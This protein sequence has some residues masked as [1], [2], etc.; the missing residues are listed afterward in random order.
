MGR[1]SPWE[2]MVAHRRSTAWASV[3]ALAAVV[4]ACSSCSTAAS[5]ATTNG[6]GIGAHRFGHRAARLPPCRPARWRRRRGGHRA[7]RH[8][9][10]LPGRSA[11]PPGPAPRGGRGRHPGQLLRRRRR[12]ARPL[13]RRCGRLRRPVPV[14]LLTRGRVPGLRGG[15]LPRA[16]G[17]HRCGERQRPGPDP[18]TGIQRDSSGGELVAA[19]AHPGAVQHHLPRP[20]RPVRVVGPPAGDLRHPRHAPGPVLALRAPGQGPGP[21]GRVHPQ[22][23]QRRRTGLGRLHR[24]QARLRTARRVSTQSGLGRRHPGLLPEPDRPRPSG[25]VAGPRP[26]GPLHRRAGLAGHTVQQR[27]HR[28]GLRDHERAAG[29]QRGG[30]APGRSLHRVLGP[31]L[32]LL[33][34]GDRGADRCPRRPTHLSGRSA[35]QPVG[36]LRLPGPGP[37]RPPVD[38]L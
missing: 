26:P 32:P 38:V 17:V 29:R 30:A 14:G 7:G 2:R 22:H 31:A 23:R 24:R 21:P 6:S 15:C 10:R 35:H 25:A 34:P 27:S 12:E 11:G 36:D 1:G 3:L 18:P 20:H 37:C 8:G 16:V 5:S 9:H 33:H 19:R 13:S 28:R 4:L